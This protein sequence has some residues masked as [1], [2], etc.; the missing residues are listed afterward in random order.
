MYHAT[1]SQSEISSQ[2]T[3]QIPITIYPSL[4]GTYHPRVLCTA[5]AFQ[6]LKFVRSR[7]VYTY[8]YIY[9]RQHTKSLDYSWNEDA[10]R[11]RERGGRGRADKL[12]CSI[13][14]L[15]E[16]KYVASLRKDL[17]SGATFFLPRDAQKKA[18]ERDAGDGKGKTRG[19]WYSLRDS[20]N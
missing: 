4:F 7:A 9:R 1:N 11:E 13:Q 16:R 15:R 5:R 14:L 10:E 20:N 6:P 19:E 17:R 18:P 8:I 2:R 3:R 12:N